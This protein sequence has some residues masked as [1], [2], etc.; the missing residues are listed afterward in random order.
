MELVQAEWKRFD[1]LIRARDTVGLV[2]FKYYLTR[3]NI[4]LEGKQ[5]GWKGGAGPKNEHEFWACVDK[6]GRT[7]PAGVDHRF[8]VLVYES[9]SPRSSR[10]SYAASY[11]GISED[12]RLGRVTKVTGDQLEAQ[13]IEVLPAA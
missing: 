10:Y 13:V 2:E 5:R 4:D 9:Y 1:L 6:L 7:A 12:D 3:P 11:F 8:L